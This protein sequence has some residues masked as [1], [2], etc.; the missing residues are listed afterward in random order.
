MSTLT[1]RYVHAATRYLSAKR[2]DDIARE[3]KGSIDDMIASRVD[4][5]ED[6]QSVERD[7]LTQMGHPDVLAGQYAERPMHLIGPRFFP[8]YLRVT[9]TILAIVPALV[10]VI[11]ALAKVADD[12]STGSAIGTGIGAAWTVVIQVVFW[13]T[14]AFALIDRFGGEDD[15][16]K[17]SLDRLPEVS[18][19]RE[20]KLVDTVASVSFIGV[21]VGVL[22]LQH[23]RS[24][25]DGPDG[26]DVPVLNPDLWSFWLPA[27]I[28]VLLASAAVEVWKYRVG[29]YSWPVVG[30]VVLT[31]VLW[32]IPFI[33]LAAEDKLLSRE[34]VDT[35]GLSSTNLDR[36]NGA[37]IVIAVAIELMTVADAAWKAR[38]SQR[39]VSA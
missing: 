30:G 5:G 12:A 3:L 38:K 18:T 35:V 36:V 37:L 23:F 24:W 26:D 11:A 19:G 32:L 6:H 9:A 1:D 10:G 17:W 39:A 20:V 15:V 2:R 22:V 31:S 16:P 7:V 27:L 28:A 29:R 14:L 8:T 25:V 13:S 21:V 34:F 4:A 33:W